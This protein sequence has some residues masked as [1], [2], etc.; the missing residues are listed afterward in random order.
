MNGVTEAQCIN[1]PISIPTEGEAVGI[2]G[3]LNS[4]KNHPR[5][6]H[7]APRHRGGKLDTSSGSSKLNLSQM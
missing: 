5:E 4:K 7:G 1:A 3:E 2:Q 6:I